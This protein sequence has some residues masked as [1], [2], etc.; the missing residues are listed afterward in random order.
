MG[1]L[2][3]DAQWAR[4]APLLSGRAS[5]KGNRRFVEAVLWL[6]RNGCRWR[7]I[8]AEWGSGT[9]RI[10]AFLSALLPGQRPAVVGRVGRANKLPLLDFRG[11]ARLERAH[12]AVSA[13]SAIYLSEPAI[14]VLIKRFKRQ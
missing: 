1:Y 3:T 13:R 8:P 5:T 6:L 10:R 12:A 9:R 2:L 7:A 4:L 11:A 14:L